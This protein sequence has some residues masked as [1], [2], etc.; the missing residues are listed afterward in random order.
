M[1][2]D[3]GREVGG[4]EL[5]EED[6]MDDDEKEDMEYVFEHFQFPP[7]RE[8]MALQTAIAFAPTLFQL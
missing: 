1:V 7:H 6:G 3:F 2:F 5:E 4:E 8:R